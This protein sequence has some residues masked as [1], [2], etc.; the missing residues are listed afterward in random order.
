MGLYCEVAAIT[1]DDT[2]SSPTLRLM[3]DGRKCRVRNVVAGKFRQIPLDFGSLY[4]TAQNACL[5]S[6]R[7]SLLLVLGVALITCDCCKPETVV[8]RNFSLASSRDQR[9]NDPPTN[10]RLHLEFFVNR[11]KNVY[12]RWGRV[13][14]SK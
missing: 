2:D 14:V 8:N 13:E 5:Q 7:H 11:V 6:S 1:I 12:V 3:A 4:G 9:G 10:P